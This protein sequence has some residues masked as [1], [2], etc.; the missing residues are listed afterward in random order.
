MG[1]F[2]LS[3]MFWDCVGVDGSVEKR[4]EADEC[5]NPG[6]ERSLNERVVSVR[7]ISKDGVKG[8]KN[9]KQGKQAACNQ[10]KY[11][12][13]RRLL[14]HACDCRVGWVTIRIIGGQ[15]SRKLHRY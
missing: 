5:R 9:Q 6:H 4:L 15:C 2:K 12:H 7:Y 8:S 1:G 13:G 10:T 3:R 11:A 14:L